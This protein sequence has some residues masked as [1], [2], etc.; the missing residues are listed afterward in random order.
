VNIRSRSGLLSD[1]IGRFDSSAVQIVTSGSIEDVLND[2]IDRGA[3]VT[4]N[5]VDT[6]RVAIL[7]G[8]HPVPSERGAESTTEVLGLAMEGG[9]TTSS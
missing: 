1:D 3:V 2:W 6:D 5:T 4:D 9:L 7:P 8:D